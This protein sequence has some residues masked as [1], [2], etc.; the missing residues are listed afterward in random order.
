MTNN[1]LKVLVIV[2]DC[3]KA[4]IIKNYGQNDNDYKDVKYLEQY[5]QII[6][7]C[8]KVPQLN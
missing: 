1:W 5:D 8:I 4:E 7:F 2:R 6:D 3:D